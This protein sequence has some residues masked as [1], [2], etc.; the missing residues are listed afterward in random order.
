MR[1]PNRFS[2]KTASMKIAFLVSG[3]TT[4][5]FANSVKGLEKSLKTQIFRNKRSIVDSS[6]VEC[7]RRQ[8][9]KKNRVQLADKN[10]MDNLIIHGAVLSKRFWCEKRNADVVARRAACRYAMALHV[11]N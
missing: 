9:Y 1:R 3:I 5:G 10:P 8:G 6:A 4:Q 11:Q 7:N 2:L